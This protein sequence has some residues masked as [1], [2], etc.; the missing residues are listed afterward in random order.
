MLNNNCAIKDPMVHAPYILI[1]NNNIYKINVRPQHLLVNGI[2]S[3]NSI[4]IRIACNSHRKKWI[5]YDIDEFVRMDAATKLIFVAL[6][7]VCCQSRLH[8]HGFNERSTMIRKSSVCVC[9]L[10]WAMYT[11]TA[12]KVFAVRH[13]ASIH[14]LLRCELCAGKVW[15]QTTITQTHFHSQLIRTQPLRDTTALNFRDSSFHFHLRLDFRQDN[16]AFSWAGACC[17][18][19]ESVS[20]TIK[21]LFFQEKNNRELFSTKF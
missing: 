19:Y 20:A 7:T 2:H 18:G 3:L 5:E 13:S 10:Q 4:P 6:L 17:R 16:S 12:L 15:R 11:Y 9:R 21:P 1:Y 8:G 14:Y